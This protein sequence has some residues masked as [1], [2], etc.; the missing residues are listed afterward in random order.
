VTSPA[1][2]EEPCPDPAEVAAQAG[3]RHVSDD[4]PGIRRVRAGRGFT[5][6]R[7]DGTTVRDPSERERLAALAVP[8]AWTDVWICPDPRGH[9]QATGRD[10]RGR[11]QYRYHPRWREVRDADKFDHLLVFGQRLG[12][13]RARVEQDLRRHGLPRERVLALVV[14]LLDDT[15]IRVGNPEYAADNDTYGL[16]TLRR[17]HVEVTD[18]RAVFDF[19]GKGGTEHHVTVDDA[20]LARLV[21]RCSELG[22]HELFT[23]ADEH[24]GVR[25][26]SSTDVNDYVREV[27]GQET[28][29]K[30]FRT[31]GGTVIAAE[32]L[33]TME[34]GEGSGAEP[35][36]EQDILAAY[37]AAAASLHN[38]RTV[39]R[40]CYVHPAVPDAYRD[41]T[42]ADHWTRSRAT[43]RLRRA[44]R[45]TLAVLN[46]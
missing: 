33:A 36:V 1:P 29:A 37:D 21:R 13:L 32:T 5:Y 28:S 34:T 23:Y 9:V 43:A 6:R 16:T 8:P 4:Q 7:A 42:L 22:G 26:V 41:G 24:D 44:E 12:D 20:R 15:L 38:T 45:A 14:R 25:E 2:S 31:W 11:K 19:V 10:Q 35:Q 46:A 39:C 27:I 17:R 30:D 40:Q 3:L 18:R